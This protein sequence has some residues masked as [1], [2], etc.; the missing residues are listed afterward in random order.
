MSDRG[1][2]RALRP[3]AGRASCI[4]TLHLSPR[5]LSCVE[6][7][8]AAPSASAVDDMPTL[9]CGE[10]WSIA[11]LLHYHLRTPHWYRPMWSSQTRCHHSQIYHPTPCLP[12]SPASTVRLSETVVRLLFMRLDI[13]QS[14]LCNTSCY[15]AQAGLRSHV[16]FSGAQL[17]WSKPLAPQ[18]C[19]STRGSHTAHPSPSPMSSSDTELVTCSECW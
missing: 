19:T 6:E 5:C 1:P 9:G 16:P 8:T 7:A 15:S 13:L 14:A 12:R 17:V 3:L 2:G 4:E 10:G 18:V 11:Y